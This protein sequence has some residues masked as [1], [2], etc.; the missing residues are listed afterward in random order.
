MLIFEWHPCGTLH[1]VLKENQ[2]VRTIKQLFQYSISLCDG[3]AYLHSIKYGTNGK[4]KKETRI[5]SFL[6]F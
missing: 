6:I 5:F 4:K 1:D 2:Q 3:L